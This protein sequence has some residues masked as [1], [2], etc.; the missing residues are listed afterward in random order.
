MSLK[1][2]AKKA[3]WKL[4][5]DLVSFSPTKHPLAR[6]RH[7]LA[8]RQIGLVLD[9]GANT[10]Q[11]AQ[12][13]RNDLEFTGRIVSFEPLLD[14][15]TALEQASKNDAK[16]QTFNFA[17]GDENKSL[18]I[19]RANNSQSSSLLEMMP[20]HVE[21][22][23]QSAY[24]GK[25]TVQVRTL[26]SVFSEIKSTGEQI[27]LKLDAQGYERNVLEGASASLEHIDLRQI[28]LSRV[29]LYKGED[30]IEDMIQYLRTLGYDLI[31]LEDS[32]FSDPVSGHMMQVDGIFSRK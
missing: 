27:L 13:L 1:K 8:H 7:I 5:L 30:L 24:V 19:N 14:A 12:Q 32:G 16:W 3:I 29:S 21:S 28:E 4:G 22:A 25:E 31:A 17:L 26:D 20:A 2:K 10:G 11:Y 9:V 23:P 18:D 15:H 6:R